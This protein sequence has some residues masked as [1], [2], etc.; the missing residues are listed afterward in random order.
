[1][2]HPHPTRACYGKTFRRSIQPSLAFRWCPISSRHVYVRVQVRT[3]LA[4]SNSQPDWPATGHTAFC[5][6]QG[7][8]TLHLCAFWLDGW[9][10]SKLSIRTRYVFYLHHLKGA[11]VTALYAYTRFYRMLRGFAGLPNATTPATQHL[12]RATCEWFQVVA[13]GSV[14]KSAERPQRLHDPPLG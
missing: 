12:Q 9:G 1:M 14:W 8:E 7:V 3:F 2:H 11:S 4:L 10:P 5:S 6:L 13:G